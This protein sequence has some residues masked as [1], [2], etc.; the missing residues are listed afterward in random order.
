ME[1]QEE[2][3]PLFVLGFFN[4][5]QRSVGEQIGPNPGASWEASG[6]RVR[7]FAAEPKDLSP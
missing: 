7:D 2:D 5:T 4:A 6:M 1:W 3:G